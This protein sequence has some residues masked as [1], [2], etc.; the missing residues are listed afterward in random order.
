MV[1]FYSP[2]NNWLTGAGIKMASIRDI[3]MSDYY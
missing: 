2:V 1:L 3:E